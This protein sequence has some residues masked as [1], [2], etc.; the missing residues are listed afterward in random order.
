MTA[1]IY[2]GQA[3][4]D[5]ERLT[6]FLLEADPDSAPEIT[7]LIIEAI[8]ILENHP[9]VGRPVELDMKEL[10]ISHGQTGYLALY[11][12]EEPQDTVLVLAI[13]HQREAGFKTTP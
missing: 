1:L 10:V 4:R 2:S 11:S 5:L 8:R 6:E 12:Y 7:D 9:L 3:L 13:R